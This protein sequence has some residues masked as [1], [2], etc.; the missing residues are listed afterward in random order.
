MGRKYGLRAKYKKKEDKNI[1][2]PETVEYVCK[3]CG[4]GNKEFQKKEMMAGGEWRATAQP[5]NDSYRS[6]HISNLMSPVMFY[7]WSRVLQ[8]FCETEFQVDAI[9]YEPFKLVR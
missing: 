8:E 7:S 1:I 6:Y 3:F 5:I 4:K 2:I 9:R